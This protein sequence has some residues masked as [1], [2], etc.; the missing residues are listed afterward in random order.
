MNE[1][2]EG[3]GLNLDF[4]KLASVAA[5]GAHVV[6][7]VLQDADNY[8]TIT[9][10]PDSEARLAAQVTKRSMSKPSAAVRRGG[11]QPTRKGALVAH[12]VVHFEIIGR[13]PEGLRNYFGELFGW[14][15][16]T[17]APVAEAVSQSFTN[18]GFCLTASKPRR[19]RRSRAVSAE[20]P[21]TGATSSSTSA[22]PM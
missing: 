15:F 14:Q 21:A 12:P 3:T 19:C 1:L 6:P 5:A 11:Q 4:G 17:S 2:E 18:Y 7:A 22:C 8:R 16:D 9:D 20:A 10:E 13:N